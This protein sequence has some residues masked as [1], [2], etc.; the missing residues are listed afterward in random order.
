[1]A[2]NELCTFAPG[3]AGDRAIP[4][5]PGGPEPPLF[6]V[7]EGAGSV[8]YAQL[9]LPHLDPRVPVYALPD[10]PVSEGR[11]RT[12]E[13]MAARL[14]RMVRETRPAGPYRLA[15]WSFGG[16]LA[17]ETARELVGRDRAV[18][19]VAMLDTRLPA[20]AAAADPVG[21]YALL[22]R[23]LRMEEGLGEIP[24][25]ALAE[26][27]S[28]AATLELEALVGR[29]REAGLLPAHVGAGRVREM[30]DRL[31][32]NRRALAEYHPQPVPVPVLL[33]AARDAAGADPRRGWGALLPGASL[34]VQP[35]PGAHTSMMEPGNVETLG[36]A[37]S[38]GISAAAHVRPS[39]TGRG[40]P[41]VTLQSGKPGGAA[42]F[43]VPGAGA[44]VATFAELAGCL[45]PS[46][47]VHGLQPRGLDG[48]GVPHSTVEAAA[49]HYLAAVRGAQPDGPVHLLGHSLGGWV[50]LEMAHRLR[51]EGRTVGSL[52]VLDSEVPGD[53]GR[54][55]EYDAR[56]ALLALVEVFEQ[57]AERP[58]GIAP[59]DLDALDEAGRLG[60]LHG[61]LVR[62]G[63]MPGRSQASSL[64]GVLRAFA[65]G[66]RTA[67]T[68]DAPYPGPLRLVLVGGP[69]L[70]EEAKLK[71]F[72]EAVR[73]W[74]RWAPELEFSPGA[75][76][77][78]T[79]LKQPHV[80]TLAALL[81]AERQGNS[82]ET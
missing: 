32:A 45:D 65:S 5:R 41:L 1:M 6:L 11:P 42:L 14:A 55:G 60:L 53:T 71:Q 58:L 66:L 24:P 47:P 29:C 23:M 75:G 50:A 80:R 8:T 67:Y 77:H 82:K 7:H 22:L 19:L 74:K 13:G 57:A 17:Y 39:R 62:A 34:R 20:G 54:P 78:V 15:G 27:V 59:A 38:G 49:E 16:L 35:V 73:G 69:G 68:P 31:Q 56:E 33:F 26:L 12:V 18:E 40:S 2:F 81:S 21:D 63:L 36:R 3:R 43:C 64:L 48:E 61:R 79:A 51:R 28:A 70:D 10:L 44:G 4:L 46:W 52:T 30:W 76:N 37:L 72:A 25:P 9:L